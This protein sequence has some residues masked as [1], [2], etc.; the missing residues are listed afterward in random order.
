MSRPR[1]LAAAGLA[2]V[3]LA[4]CGSTV[5]LD[6]TVGPDASGLGV[7]TL[8]VATGGPGAAVGPDGTQP[9]ESAA[10]PGGVTGQ[11]SEATGPAGSGGPASAVTTTRAGSAAGSPTSVAPGASASVTPRQSSGGSPVEIGFLNT[12]VSNAASFGV[13]TG[14]TFAPE[15]VFQALVKYLNA[16]GGLDGRQI[17]PVV[18]Q[19][20]TA[21]ASWVTDYQAACS[22]FT[23][24]NHVAAVV[25]YS[26]AFIENF[27]ACLSKAGVIHI[28]GGYATGDAE[29]FRQYPYLVSTTGITDDRRYLVQVELG[30]KDGLLR[31]GSKLGIVIDN[32]AEEKRAYDDTVLPYLKA[33]HVVPILAVEGCPQGASDDA[34]AIA[35]IQAAVLKFRS[36][37]VNRIMTEGPPI[38][39]FAL[40]AQAQGWHPQYLLTSATG[41][42]VVQDEVPAGQA[43][44]VHGAGWLP[45][46]DVPVAH[47][48]PLTAPERHC[49]AMLKT[50]GMVPRQYNDFLYAYTTCDGLSLY[51]TALEH[52]GDSTNAGHVVSAIEALG[53]SWHGASMVDGATRFSASDRDGPADYRVFGW[54]KSCSCFAYTG[55]VESLP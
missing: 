14:Q 49:L 32:C 37:G 12:G 8:V 39:V 42:A 44:Y 17:K 55:P 52:D 7:P 48:A 13:S 51:E 24:D 20:D 43:Q 11:P 35:Q 41:G 3:A 15:T 23:Q 16:H 27:E 50:E 34:S 36:Q 28:N 46:V 4:G 2:L 29:S 1:L 40:E 31:A 5:P 33:H 25:G 38:L 6:R 18:A 53:T 19:T 22:S 9:S 10:A 54:A 21:D 26:F 30:V 47:R 45:E